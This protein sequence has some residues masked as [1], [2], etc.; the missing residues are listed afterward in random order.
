MKTEISVR[1]AL[2]LVRYSRQ[3]IYNLVTD[4]VVPARREGHELRLDRS[5]LLVHAKKHNRLR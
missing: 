2:T 1:E 4:L 5:A 3:Q